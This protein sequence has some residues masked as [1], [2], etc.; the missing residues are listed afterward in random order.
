MTETLI[1]GAV[2]ELYIQTLPTYRVPTVKTILNNSTDVDKSFELMLKLRLSTLRVVLYL[3][4]DR[5]IGV[6]VFMLSLVEL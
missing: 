2:V 5:N 3:R 4:D 6:G 1:L